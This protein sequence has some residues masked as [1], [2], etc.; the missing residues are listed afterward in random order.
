MGL[1]SLAQRQSL[2]S[3]TRKEIIAAESAIKHILN[4]KTNGGNCN[5]VIQVSNGSVFNTNGPTPVDLKMP[6]GT[7]TSGQPAPGTPNIFVNR[8][9]IDNPARISGNTNGTSYVLTLYMDASINVAGNTI[10][11]PTHMLAT[12]LAGSDHGVLVNCN[13]GIT[14]TDDRTNCSSFSGTMWEPFSQKCFEDVPRQANGAFLN[15]PG[16][17]RRD[18]NGNCVPYASSCPGG[19]ISTGFDHSIIANCSPP[20]P[21]YIIIARPAPTAAAVVPEGTLPP[22]EQS[23]AALGNF[24]LGPPVNIQGTGANWYPRT[25]QCSGPATIGE[26]LVN[27]CLGDPDCR[28]PATPPRAA[29]RAICT[30][31]IS[32]DYSAPDLVNSTPDSSPPVDNTCICGP[33]RI[34][35]AQNEVCISCR[36][37]DSGF[38][39]VNQK[40][41]FYDGATC[42]NGNL[43]PMPTYM[44]KIDPGGSMSNCKNQM[45]RGVCPGGTNCRQYYNDPGF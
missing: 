23:N 21:G 19:T 43:V 41:Y 45:W 13:M 30:D 8:V 33:Y 20:P 29:V 34:D 22:A 31:M 36:Y 42:V 7:Y 9:Y 25:A 15:C 16:G 27:Q 37:R 5:T 26:T 38:L 17:M 28:P 10:P 1:V 4:R 12:I 35:G 39:G 32:N 14:A 24:N 3:D 2:S 44:T 18:N 6:E 11:L 40:T